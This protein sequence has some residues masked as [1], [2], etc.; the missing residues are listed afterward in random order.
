MAYIQYLNSYGEWAE[1]ERMPRERAEVEA[2][3]MP[4]HMDAHV[5]VCGPF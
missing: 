1:T 4:A 5:R 3:S 2:A